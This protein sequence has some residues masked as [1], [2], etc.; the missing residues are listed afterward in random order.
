MKV[1]DDEEGSADVGGG[2]ADVIAM[3]C[4]NSEPTQENVKTDEKLLDREMES[5]SISHTVCVEFSIYFEVELDLP[6]S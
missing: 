1:L 5:C 2:G 4:A 3:G 6:P